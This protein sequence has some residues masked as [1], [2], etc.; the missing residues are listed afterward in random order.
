[1]ME[2]L[3]NHGLFTPPSLKGSVVYPGSLGG[4]NW[5]SASFD[6][7][8]GTLYTRVSNLGFLVKQ[9]PAGPPGD[10]LSA[11]VERK[12]KKYLPEWMGGDPPPYA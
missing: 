8:T 9:V 7:Q 6:P 2:G 4:A 3:D 11:R 5:G 10:G 1:M 12:A